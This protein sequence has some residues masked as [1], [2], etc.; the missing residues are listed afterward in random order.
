MKEIKKRNNRTFW[1]AT[2]GT[3]THRGFTEANQV[4]T[5]GLTTITENKVH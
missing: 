2:N 4:T 5:T 1:E 3:V